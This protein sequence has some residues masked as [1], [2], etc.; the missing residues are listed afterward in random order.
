M[1]VFVSKNPTH[2][3][4]ESLSCEKVNWGGVGLFQLQIEKK[5]GFGKKL[6]D[7]FTIVSFI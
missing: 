4:R 2:L 7:A 6:F 3:S 1:L 5:V